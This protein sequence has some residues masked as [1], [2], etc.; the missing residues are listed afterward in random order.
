[1]SFVTSNGTLTGSLSGIPQFSG[2]LSSP[3]SSSGRLSNATLRGESVKLRAVGDTIQYRYNDNEEW[4]DLLDVG[5]NLD[6]E[7]LS[8]SEIEALLK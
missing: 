2:T 3:G 4:T 8:N 7:F 5:S 6:V 1:M